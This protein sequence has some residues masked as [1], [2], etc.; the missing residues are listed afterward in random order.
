MGIP[1]VGGDFLKELI[2]PRPS[3]NERQK[4][5]KFL[6]HRTEVINS[7][8]TRLNQKLFILEEKRS[9]IITQAVTKGLN[10]NVQLKD[11]G[12]EWLGKIPEHW[13]IIPLKFL[14]K[15]IIDTEH[16]TV[17]FVD[18]GEYMVARTTNIKKGRLITK[19]IRTTD[20]AGYEGW[21]RRGV[22]EAGD[23]I[24][25][26]EA[27]AGEACV[28]PKSVNLCLG[29]RTVLIKLNQERLVPEFL[30]HSIYAGLAQ[31]F[32]SVLS[33]GSTVPHFNM[34]DIYN[35]PIL[36]PPTCAEQSEIAE[37]VSAEADLVFQ[38]VQNIHKQIEGL[39]EYR[40][41]LITAAVTGKIDIRESV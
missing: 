36:L 10:S 8:I 37:F 7:A 31:R 27:P 21:T 17:H 26:R 13:T 29:Q 30:L 28:V 1:H 9:A 15:K 41:C 25:T 2:L 6:N 24:L 18:D 14:V 34:A 35:I 38:G 4:I 32:I 23:I 39:N 20:L 22:P 16:K 40:K 5:A 19:N 11:S 12:I 33:A 3:L